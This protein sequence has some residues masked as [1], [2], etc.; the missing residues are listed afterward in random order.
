MCVGD[1]LF[2][3][4]FFFFGFIVNRNYLFLEKN[5]LNHSIEKKCLWFNEEIIKPLISE[6]KNYFS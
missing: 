6:R 5:D 4:F 3:T 2:V 1:G